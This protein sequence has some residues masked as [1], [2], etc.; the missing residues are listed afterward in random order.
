MITSFNVILFNAATQTRE[1]LWST[2][3]VGLPIPRAGE[4]LYTNKGVKHVVKS[5]EYHLDMMH[6]FIV[7]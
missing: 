5:I 3:Q 6:I 2:N 4:V 1:P 7:V